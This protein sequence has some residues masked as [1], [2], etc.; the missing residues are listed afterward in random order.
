MSYYTT[1]KMLYTRLRIIFYNGKSKLLA[2]IHKSLL[3][4]DHWKSMEKSHNSSIN[5]YIRH[6]QIIE[7]C[8]RYITNILIQIRINIHVITNVDQTWYLYHLLSPF[9]GRTRANTSSL[10]NIHLL[11]F[12]MLSMTIGVSS[13]TVCDLSSLIRTRTCNLL[14]VNMNNID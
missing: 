7:Y 12:T 4:M 3:G 13:C 6:S 11:S 5:M 1:N 10:C 9:P 2:I 8:Y 14:N